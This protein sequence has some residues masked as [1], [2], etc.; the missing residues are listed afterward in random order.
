MKQIKKCP[1]YYITEEGE[2][3]S[4]RCK[5]E[6]K[7]K[8]HIDTYGYYAI[9]MQTPDG[10]LHS[11][12]I[13]RLMILT[14]GSPPPKDM[15]NPTVDHINGNK[16][17]NRIQNLQWLSNEENALKAATHLIKAYTIEHKNGF[18]FEVENLRN[19]CSKNNLDDCSMRRSYKTGWWHKDYR[20]IGKQE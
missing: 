7:L 1:D 12:R 14:Y 10:K 16:L 13:H 5:K 2:I 9:G 19:W 18:V 8:P 15:K 6:K 20:I 17:D 11:E 3:I 4:R